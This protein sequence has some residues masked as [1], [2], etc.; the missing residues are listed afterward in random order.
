MPPAAATAAGRRSTSTATETRPTTPKRTGGA[1]RT[2]REARPTREVRPTRAPKAP[3]RVSG[4]L[5]RTDAGQA[6]RPAVRPSARAL[7]A[8]ATLGSAVSP[9][10]SRPRRESPA[11]SRRDLSAGLARLSFRPQATWIDRIVRGRAW[12]PLLG[13]TLVAVVGLRVEVL[14]LGS[15]VGR[16]LQQVTVLQS[17]N[18]VL[19]SQV[20]A[21][22]DN[23]RIE[24]MAETMGMVM[25]GP[26]DIHFLKSS[27]G[28]HVGAAIRAI[29]APSPSAFL[30]GIAAERY[31]N[32]NSTT[33][34]ANQSAIGALS[35]G[36]ITGSGST[37]SSTPTAAT[38]TGASG[39][40]GATTSSYTGGV[41]GTTGSAQSTTG[42]QSTTAVTSGVN[43][44]A[45]GSASG[46]QAPPAS[47]STSPASGSSTSTASGSTTGG[48]GLAG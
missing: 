9:A 28:L 22:S 5:S 25:P 10:R 35:T 30:N 40:A 15:S 29:S 7:A 20:S 17:A 1:P 11:A 32:A 34:A 38:G 16:Q 4:P 12:I 42:S 47:S 33:V 8:A 23:A 45:A 31:T 26:M 41:Q 21:L 36:T 18:A 27:V 43:A 6:A 14:K 13:V 37:S 44:G 46:S 24:G 48:T 2:T 3:R 39:A 19:R